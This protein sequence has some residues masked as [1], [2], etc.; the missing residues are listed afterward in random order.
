MLKKKNEHFQNMVIEKQIK[1]IDKI[2][3]KEMKWNDI[4]LH[5][6]DIKDRLA[7]ADNES[8]VLATEVQYLKQMLPKSNLKVRNSPEKPLNNEESSL[9]SSNTKIEIELS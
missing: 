7:R 3:A 5:I 1:S 4:E 6:T 9:F 2:L 8:K